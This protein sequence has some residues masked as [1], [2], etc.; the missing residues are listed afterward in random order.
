M[1]CIVDN[2]SNNV[3]DI[4]PISYCIPLYSTRNDYLYIPEIYAP[5]WR[6]QMEIICALLALCERNPSVTGGFPPQKPVG[7]SFDVFF[8]MCLT[9]GWAN[10]RDAGD[11]IRHIT[12]YDVT[13]MVV[14]E[15]C[16]GSIWDCNIA[17]ANAQEVLR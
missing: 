3:V 14:H 17:I 6:H 13:V 12:H 15:R 7:R 11:L 9:N 8:E 16:N 4:F 2:T 10:S 5:W 1:I